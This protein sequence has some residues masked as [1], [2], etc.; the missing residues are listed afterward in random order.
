M[1]EDPRGSIDYAV[2]GSGPTL[3]LVPGSWGTRSAG[4]G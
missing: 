2:E 1:I 4:A 3:L